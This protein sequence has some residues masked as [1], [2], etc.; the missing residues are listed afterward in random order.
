M[1][2]TFDV[3]AEAGWLGEGE[4]YELRSADHLVV[5]D[6]KAVTWRRRE[7]ERMGFDPAPVS[8]WERRADID[9]HRV[10]GMLRLDWTHAQVFAVI[11]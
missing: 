10:E 2:F 4:E 11:D 8:A 6:P 7:L 9:L 3:D 5:A 1:S